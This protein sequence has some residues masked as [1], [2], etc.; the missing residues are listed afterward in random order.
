VNKNGRKPKLPLQLISAVAQRN[1]VFYIGSGISMEAGLPSGKALSEHLINAMSHEGKSLKE[2]PL[3][4]VAQQYENIQGRPALVRTL[5]EPIDRAL[6]H[7]NTTPFK[8]LAQVMPH[9]V[10]IITTNWDPLIEDTFGPGAI[11]TVKNERSLSEHS[12]AG[13]NLYK[14]HGDLD[15]FSE[16]TIT[17]TDYVMFRQNHAGFYEKIRTLFREKTIL[18][19][20]YSTEDWDFLEMYLSIKDELDKNMNP[21]Y[22]VTPDDSAEVQDRLNRLGIHHIRKRAGRFLRT[23]KLEVEPKLYEQHPKFPNPNLPEVVQKNPF[24]V[25]RAED[26][27]EELWQHE[28]FR[29]PKLYN[30]FADTIA[31]GNVIIEGHRGSGKSTILL[32]LSYPIQRILGNNPDFVGVYV[33]LDLPLFATTRRRG[34]DKDEWLNY[35]LAYFNLIVA[36]EI[37]R[38]LIDLATKSFV[39]LDNVNELL[40]KLKS[41]FPFSRD[42][43]VKDLVD[44]ADLL[45]EKRSE[46]AG[47]PPR[48]Q[49]KLP[50]DLLRSLV[51]R[52][53]RYIPSWRDKP[54]YILLDE[55]ERLSEDQQK[56]VNVLL[57]S[58]G[59]TYKEK[60][61]F[62]I[63][64]KSFMFIDTNIEGNQLE[65]IHDFI[66]RPL[67]RFDLEEEN[68][69]RHYQGFIEE[70][71]NWRL[72]K[73]WNYGITIKELLPEERNESKRGFENNDYA[74]FENVATLS[75]FLPRDFLELCKDMV[76]YAYPNLISETKRVKLQPITANLQ[77]TVVKIHADNL[78]EN[79]NRITD[80]DRKPVP[81]TRSESARRLIESW[82]Q[83]FRRI[84]KGSKSVE[85]RT[86]SEF[87]LRGA[88]RLDEQAVSALNDCVIRRALVIP[89]TKRRP[90]VRHNIPADRY[91]LHRLLCARFGLSLARRWPKDID[92]GWLNSLV[93]AKNPKKI[94]DRLTKY[95]ISTGQFP[96]V[97]Q[98]LFDGN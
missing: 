88:S 34:E 27:S 91:E 68:K 51:D 37:I 12:E 24:V 28:L 19:I 89:L 72:Q 58:R 1:C 62:K 7:A 60:V 78:L 31:P 53:R 93:A 4:R 67:D 25:F 49:V 14:V 65:E 98:T 13:P 85:D 46:L 66:L 77:N 95:F 30:I 45:Y 15:Y 84:L 90:Q 57:S 10:E 92:A 48:T 63:A 23:L 42:V 71:A 54:F 17:E 55:Y 6:K 59:P 35:F 47:P 97:E 75:S 44:L 94:I 81:H 33:K 56:V 9:P 11:I 76:F 18:F 87:Q 83:I 36:E 39:E 41:L 29:E 73:I 43:E 61:Y 80:E 86:V 40:T 16:A 22:C 64:A 21:R 38:T 52:M 32:Y 70:I 2:M 5:R 82:G 96:S 74:G 8:L 69:R 26:M 20:G 79:L 3:Y 50:P